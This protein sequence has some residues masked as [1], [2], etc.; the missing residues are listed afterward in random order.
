MQLSRYVYVPNGSQN[1]MPK[2]NIQWQ[3][4]IPNGN[5]QKS[6][7]RLSRSSDYA[8][9]GHFTYIV[10]QRTT[11]KCTKIYDDNSRAK[12][13]F[14]HEFFRLSSDV[15]VA[16]I[17]LPLLLKTVFDFSSDFPSNSIFMITNSC[18]N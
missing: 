13:C 7:R 15:L 5:T 11:K 3:R 6:S 2:L 1:G 14:G 18:S 10:S 8:E 9:F 4:L 16:V 12:L 17:V